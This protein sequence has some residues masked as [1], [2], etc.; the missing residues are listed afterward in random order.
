MF[1]AQFNVN[2]FRQN[3]KFRV[4]IHSLLVFNSS[5]W[6]DILHSYYINDVPY[7]YIL[8]YHINYIAFKHI[9]FYLHNSDCTLL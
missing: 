1:C 7:Y 6:H 9:V 3:L 4:R 2:V 8:G 5:I